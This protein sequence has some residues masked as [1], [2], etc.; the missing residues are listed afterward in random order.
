[1]K[2][3][4]E[5]GLIAMVIGAMLLATGVVRADDHEPASPTADPET[6]EAQGA[7][8]EGQPEEPS[9]EDIEEPE[10]L[11][12]YNRT[13]E[14]IN[15]IDTHRVR[16]ANVLDNQ[17]IIFEMRG[18]RDYLNQLPYRCSQLGFHESFSYT[19]RGLNKLCNV[20]FITVITST[21]PGASCGLG[22]FE[23]LEKKSR[24]D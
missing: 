3:N 8:A 22:K 21:G 20:D 17:H 23:K 15:C 4:T 13:G 14:F 18:G 9:A 24:K 11:A 6:Q 10:E 19:L 2:R 16:N 7:E 5:N 1:M 12:K